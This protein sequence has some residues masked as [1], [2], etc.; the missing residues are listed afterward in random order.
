M[1]FWR[2]VAPQIPEDG[3]KST[4]TPGYTRSFREINQKVSQGKS[5]SGY[6]RNSLFLNLEG[7][8]FTDVAGLF[9]VDFDDDARAVATVDWDR[10]GDL[11]LWITNR[12]APQVRLLK[13]NA[14]S[15]NSFLAIRLIGNGKSTNRDAIGARLTLWQ[16][17]ASDHKQIRTVHAGS[18]FLAQSSVWSHFGLGKNDEDLNLS[19]RWPG[20]KTESFTGIKSN[21][22]YTITQGQRRLIAMPVT[23]KLIQ[24][25]EVASNDNAGQ[26]GFWVANRVPFP[27]LTYTDDQGKD[28]T[29]TDLRGKPVLITLWATWCAPCLEELKMLRENE[30]ALLAGGTKIL[31][32]NVDGLVLDD[33]AAAPAKADEVLKR[34]GFQLPNG[35]A[36][37]E[38]LAKIEVLIEFLSSRR[39]PLSLPSSFLIDAEGRIAAVYL[40][41]L[42]WDQLAND[43]ALLKAPSAKQLA[44]ISPRTGRWLVDPRQIDHAANLSNYATLFATSGLTDE[45]QRLYQMLNTQ[46][47]NTSAQDYYNQAKLAA[48]QG[49]TDQAIRHYQDAIRV[50]PDY[51]QALTGLGA[52]LLMQKRVD[53]AERLFEKALSIDPNHATA[54]INLAMIERS[55]G[56]VDSAL[57][58]LRNVVARNPSYAA[59]YLNL[60]SLLA[61]M[62]QSG[63]AIQHLSKAVELQPR[64]AV[65]HLNLASLYLETD[66]LGK[67][68]AHYLHVQKLNPRIPHAHFGLAVLQSRQKNHTQAVESFRKAI[69][70]GSK[71]PKV[72]AKMGLSLLALGKPKEAAEALQRALRLNPNDDEAKRALREIEIRLK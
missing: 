36:N 22:H 42:S 9:D 51:G 7:K 18:G 67:A 6:E 19:V 64:N 46:G 26:N 56:D 11:D 58:R 10:D 25:D 61:S 35:F 21:T 31:A 20:G 38:G 2:R 66:Q 41:T 54:Q 40:E 16:S 65:A 13:N 15:T 3:L 63:E 29:T 70:L 59:A 5:F 52:L 68:E 32:L 57:G 55:R 37:K 72:Y 69:A 27:K 44:R 48:Q 28:H 8:R 33:D 71:N 50:K 47:A 30:T 1:F 12:T 49:R 60:G 45:S 34:I 53:E 39:S 43:L 14:T 62:K 4:A 23:R 17:S 24:R